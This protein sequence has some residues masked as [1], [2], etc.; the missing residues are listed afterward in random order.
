MLLGLAVL[1]GSQ[2]FWFGRDKLEIPLQS[3]SGRVECA[4]LYTDLSS[5]DR[6]EHTRNPLLSSPGLLPSSSK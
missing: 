2:E 3:L 4:L 1:G 6:S 5:A